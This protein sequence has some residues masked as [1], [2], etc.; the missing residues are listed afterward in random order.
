MG[1][2]PTKEVPVHKN[3]PA[4]LQGK[5]VHHP[6]VAHCTSATVGRR[7]RLEHPGPTTTPAECLGGVQVF[8]SGLN[9]NLIVCCAYLDLQRYVTDYFQYSKVVIVGRS[10]R[11]T[12][13]CVHERRR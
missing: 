7:F 4:L 10:S 13:Q 5:P 3:I 11:L 8:G 9:A 2:G 6:V 12:R 1:S